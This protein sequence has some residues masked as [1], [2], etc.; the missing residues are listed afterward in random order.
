MPI[1]LPESEKK[2]IVIIG[3]GFGGLTLAKKLRKTDFQVVLIDKNNYHQFQPL[4][5]QVAMAGL[6]PSSITYP[7]RKAFQNS[8]NIH[9]RVA[10]VESVD[11][12]RKRVNT[13]LGYCNYDYLVLALGA[14]TNYFGNANFEK[15]T[16]SLKS[17]SE[18]LSLRNAIFDDLE[19]ALVTRDYEE[20]QGYI[21]VVI[22]GGGATGVELA[23]SLAE[24]KKYILPKD[25]RELDASEVDIY[26]IQGAD[27]LLKGM[28]EEASQKAKEF[29]EDLGVKVVFNAR[30]TG[31]DG[32]YV[33][34]KDGQKIS[35]KKVIWAAGVNCPKIEGIEEEA[36][37]WGNRLKVDSTLKVI[38][39]DDIY[40]IGDLAYLVEGEYVEGHPQVAQ[41]AIQMAKHLA[42]N[43]KDSGQR[44]FAYDDLGSMATVGRNRA[45]VDLPRF[46]F[47]GFFAWMVWLFVHLAS[48][49]G[50]KNKVFVLLNWFWSYVTYDQSL[51]LILKP[52]DKAPNTSGKSS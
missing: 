35:A 49:V 5:Y 46:K 42:R 17:V 11:S 19:K 27:K 7:L 16:Y 24:M 26:L 31:Y 14:K 47:Q 8:D 9:I 20:R 34:T 18:A 38:G 36:M 15:Y 44:P 3:A 33:T 22:V 48:L 40:A 50:F 39:Y 28:S 37:T 43:L 12:A 4:F 25:Y 21:D 41:V 29:L 32:Q 52:S 1:N 51:R 45:V 13:S 23:G 2:R 10:E 30:V 6:E